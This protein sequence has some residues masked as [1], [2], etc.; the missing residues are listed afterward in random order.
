VL[1][2][3]GDRSARIAANRAVLERFEAVAERLAAAGAVEDAIAATVVGAHIGSLMH[4][5]VLASERLE[6]VLHG[7]ARE[8]LVPLLRRERPATPERVLHV[9]TEVYGVGGHTRVIWRWIAR[10]PGR[11]HDIVLTEQW[12]KVPDGLVE[13]VEASGG[14]VLKL[15]PQAPRL[16]R[17]RAL[18]EI[19]ADADVAVMYAHHRDPIPVLAFSAAGDRPP[20]ITFNHADHMLWLGY[21]V[22][23]VLQCCR[24]NPAN[25]MRGLPDERVLVTPFPVSGPDGHAPAEPPSAEARAEA[26]AGVLAQLGWPAE[27]LVVL[28]VGH[29]HKYSGPRGA[30]LLDMVGDVLAGVPQARL[31]AVGARDSGAFAELRERTGG[32]VAA[33]GPVAGIGPIFT[34]ADVYLESWPFGGQSATAEASAHRLPVLSYAPNEV[35]A[36]LLCSH[37]MYGANLAG[38]PEE[39]RGTLHEL[40]VDP[41]RR[42]ALAARSRAA[43]AASDGAWEESVGRAY[44]L[45]GELG[46]VARDELTPPSTANPELHTISHVVQETI[47]AHHP[48][49][50]GERAIASLELAARSPAVRDLFSDAFTDRFCMPELRRRYVKAFAAPP[51]T[52]EALRAVIAEFRSLARIGATE[53]HVLAL[54]PDDADAAVPV[55]EAAIAEG[56]DVDVELMLHDNPRGLRPEWSLEVIAPGSVAFEPPVHPCA[57]ARSAG[58]DG[59]SRV[60]IVI[61][62]YG[63]RAVTERGLEILAGALGDGLGERFELVLVDNGSPDDTAELFARWAN[64]ATVVSLDRNRNFSG[65]CNAGAAAATGDVLIFLNNDVDV[66]PGALEELAATLSEPGVGAAGARLLY[67][68]GDI[69]HAGVALL[70]SGGLPIPH[71][72]FHHQAG[73]LPAARGVYDV[74]LVTGAC[75]AVRAD[76]FGSLGGFD[77]AFANG[78]EDMDL[79]LRVRM[80]GERVVYRG[81]VELIHHEGRTRGQVEG[82]DDNAQVFYRRWRELIDDDAELLAR[83]FDGRQRPDSPAPERT[84]RGGQIVLSGQISGTSPGADE[85]RALLTAL[86]ASGFEPVLAEPHVVLVEPSLGADERALLERCAA[87]AATPGALQVEVVDGRLLAPGGGAVARLGG[88][89]AAGIGEAQAVWASSPAAV[90]AL[91][92]AGLH[93]ERIAMLPPP[94]L[95]VELG[96]GG[97]GLLVHLPAHDRGAVEALLAALAPLSGVPIRLVPNVMPNWLRARVAEVLPAAQL[98]PACSSE[99]RFAALAATADAAV[100]IDADE[101]HQRRALVAAAAGAAPVA[102]PGGPASHVLGDRLLTGDPATAIQRALEMAGDRAGLAAAVAAECG[103]D[104][105]AE[106]LRELVA[107]TLLQVPE[108]ALL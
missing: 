8:H 84:R 59:A 74:E 83:A 99:R 45:A 65:G 62:A 1:E 95:D 71:H 76:L 9:A 80:A 103:P 37:P 75:L 101:P 68:D 57:V 17:A 7:I 61:V 23:D 94:V 106:R 85:A 26:R 91:V 32:R 40:L 13:A 55:L 36:A 58:A 22:T 92:A 35:E 16:V 108:S 60:S 24:P 51:P 56:A 21:S 82:T 97:E 69:Q 86:E 104:V 53:G 30:T 100:C 90:D 19:A 67:P 44:E 73:D 49:L 39:Y 87:R 93:S 64:R 20:T 42:A 89:P 47:A 5:G 81:D 66:L 107:T 48:G 31:L 41:E 14:R 105:T 10:D 38:S 50:D 88:L 70:R 46:P 72:V 2:A 34:T 18:R 29:E 77:E 96:D 98:L 27:S 52:P 25:L 54:H 11:V 6:A 15:D 12:S 3:A 4:S 102:L 33:L 43:V 63:Q 78:W 79:C 28:T